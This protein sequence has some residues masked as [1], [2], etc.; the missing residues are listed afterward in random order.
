LEKAVVAIEAV[1]SSD[2]KFGLIHQHNS[3]IELSFPPRREEK[4]RVLVIRI[5]NTTYVK[6]HLTTSTRLLREI[7]Q[8]TTFGA[9]QD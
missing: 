9:I 3:K 8:F 1:P 2:N 5:I 6:K 4:P 7:R